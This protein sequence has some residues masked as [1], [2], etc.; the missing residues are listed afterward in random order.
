VILIT[1][2][3]TQNVFK[4]ADMTTRNVDGGA[5]LIAA[6]QRFGTSRTEVP[7][8]ASVGMVNDS[9]AIYTRSRRGLTAR[10]LEVAKLV[11]QGMSNRRVSETLRLEE[12]SVKN[13][14]SA[15]LRKLGCQNRVQVALKL[16]GQPTSVEG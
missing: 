8:K 1:N 4:A 11:A 10:E 2:P 7:I 13:L 12:Q 3:D 5:A 15:I 16:T 9:G 14:V 6:A